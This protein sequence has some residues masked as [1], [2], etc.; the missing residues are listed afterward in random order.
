MPFLNGTCRGSR[1]QDLTGQKFGNLEVTGLHKVDGGAFWFCR[2]TCG[3]TVSV[4]AGQLKSGQKSCSCKIRRA[5]YRDKVSAGKHG[6][7]GTP[8]HNVWMSMLQRCFDTRCKCY[9]R[10]GGRGITVCPRWLEFQ[11]F[12]ADM[13]LRPSPQHSIDR[14]YNNGDYGPANCRWA[15]RTEQA[16]NKRN[17]RVLTAQGISRTMAEWSRVSG[18]SV[19]TIK[20]RIDDL[21]WAVERAVSQPVKVGSLK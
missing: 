10:Y 4:R 13:G 7:C 8:E 14:I 16:N 15:T 1:F 20:R 11:E 17:S 9:P 12:L 5:G 21:G 6:Q 2:C 18:I 3:K 19:V